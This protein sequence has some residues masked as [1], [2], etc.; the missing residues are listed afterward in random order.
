MRLS[1][2]AW[3]LGEGAL[4][5]RGAA[6]GWLGA[7]VIG[8][9]L[10]FG[11]LYAFADTTWYLVPFL[12]G[13]AFIAAWVL[14]AVRVYRRAQGMQAARPPTPRG[15]PAAAIVWLSVPL[16]LWGTGFWLIG[17]DGTSPGAVLNRFVAEW[18]TLASGQADWAPSLA[19]DPRALTD[20]AAAALADLRGQCAAGKLNSDCAAAPA[21]LLHDVRLRITAQTDTTAEAV[22]EAVAYQQRPTRVLFVFSGTELVPVPRGVVL[23]LQLVAVPAPHDL[24]RLGARR[25]QIVSAERP[26]SVGPT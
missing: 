11:S 2:L 23:Q 14:Q 18:P 25:W 22:A 8:L 15:S 6:L 26:A 7:E 21:N 3:G 24:L 10:V 4:G 13:I 17:A 5:N 19:A 9:A 16:L 1:I 20:A 12:L